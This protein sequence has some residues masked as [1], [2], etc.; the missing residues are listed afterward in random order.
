MDEGTLQSIWDGIVPV[1]TQYGLSVLGALAILIVGRIA[2][3]IASRIVDRA[4]TRANVEPTIRGFTGHLVRVAVLAFA[5]IAALSR[6]GIE[7]TSFVAVLGAAGFAIGFALQGS[8]SNFAAGVMLLIFRPIRVGDLVNVAGYVGT[9][10][11]IGIFV[12]KVDTLDNQHIIIPNGKLTG[13]VINNMSVNGTRRV[14]MVAGI[15]YGDNIPKAKGI[16][17]EILESHPKVL[18][19]PAPQV[20]V[21]EL[22][23]SSVDFVVRPW[24]KSDDYWDV[25]FDVTEAIKMRFDADG[26]T[27]PFPQRDVHLHQAG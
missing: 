8:L 17:Q 25:W 3:N 27:I 20:A 5:V 21:Y 9:V 14:D 1:I 22:G 13:D 15:G 26:V 16:L 11:E 4:M 19:E 6:F 18:Q 7:T 24:C 23:E 12:T 10:A 2:A